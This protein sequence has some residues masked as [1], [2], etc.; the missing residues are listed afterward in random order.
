MQFI[1]CSTNIE[2]YVLGT[3]NTVVK[4][5]T[6]LKEH[7]VLEENIIL[8]NLFST[9]FAAKAVVHAFPQVLFSFSIYIK[10]SII[11]FTG[12]GVSSSN[13]WYS[14]QHSKFAERPDC[15]VTCMYSTYWTY[16]C[17]SIKNS[18]VL[19]SASFLIVNCCSLVFPV[20]YPRPF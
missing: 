4:A 7:N 6:V 16:F 20:R 15:L 8:S 12:N 19:R 13:K 14:V 17:V 2:I 5:V 11:K 9:P 1:S 10:F 3:G 18:R